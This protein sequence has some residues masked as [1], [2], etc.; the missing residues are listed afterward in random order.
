MLCD[1]ALNSAR[2]SDSKR[3][4]PIR[5][6]I[7]GT[8]ITAIERV[9]ADQCALSSVTWIL[10]EDC[11]GNR[12]YSFQD[13]SVSTVSVLFCEVLHDSIGTPDMIFEG[14]SRF[15]YYCGGGETTNRLA[16]TLSAIHVDLR[17]LCHIISGRRR[18]RIKTLNPK[19]NETVKSFQDANIDL[20]GARILMREH[21]LLEKYNLLQSLFALGLRPASCCV[22]S[23]TD[24]TP[25]RDLIADA[26]LNEGVHVVRTPDIFGADRIDGFLDA[27]EAS[28]L[29]VVDDGGDLVLHCS[30]FFAQRNKF[31]ASV[32]YFETTTKGVKLLRHTAPEVQFVDLSSSLTKDDMSCGIAA[33][34]VSRFRQILHREGLN[35]EPVHVVGFGRLGEH[36]ALQLRA[37][38]MDVSV[39]DIG[40]SRREQAIAKGF[41]TYDAPVEALRAIQPRFLIAAS[42]TRSIGRLELEAMTTPAVLA[43]ASSQDLRPAIEYLQDRFTMTSL[44]EIGD[45]YHDGG[46]V[47]AVVLGHGDALNLFRAEGVNDPDFDPFVTMVFSS[48]VNACT[49]DMGELNDVDV[50]SAPGRNE[51][52]KRPLLMGEWFRS[53]TTS[54]C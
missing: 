18:A 31:P 4:D 34:V 25:Y 32:V 10:E 54:A 30:R 41:A 8:E 46:D 21:F 7:T 50:L 35:C 11:R 42:G 44:M 19:L 5:I 45:F 6:P 13:G 28:R 51:P 53:E 38:G 20:S 47:T 2:I 43:S 36:I 33:S 49:I 17:G 23:K 39:S 26:L 14:L 1:Q 24:R 15:T 16:E 37:M 27:S 22:I 29:I 48:I 40:P 9:I 52:G 12:S 3:L